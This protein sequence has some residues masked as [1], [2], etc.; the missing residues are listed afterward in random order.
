M[1]GQ[2]KE[3]TVTYILHLLFDTLN[4]LKITFSRDK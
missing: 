1:K 2:D 4:P 3:D